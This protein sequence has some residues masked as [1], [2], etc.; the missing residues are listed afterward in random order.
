MEIQT[1]NQNKTRQ[2]RAMNRKVLSGTVIGVFCIGISPL[3]LSCG[4]VEKTQSKA[5]S[6]FTSKAWKQQ[7]EW[8]QDQ[9]DTDFLFYIRR[10]DQAEEL[11]KNAIEKAKAFGNSDPR[12]ARSLTSLGRIQ[13]NQSNYE[14]AHKSLSHAF[15][16]K[17]K[18]FGMKNTDV[19]D[20]LCELAYT[21]L[22]QEDLEGANNAAA[23]A[24]NI[25][26]E[27]NDQYGIIESD[28][29]AALILSKQ[30][31]EKEALATYGNCIKAY[32]NKIDNPLETLSSENLH[33]MKNCFH[34]YIELKKTSDPS[35]NLKDEEAELNKLTAWLNVLG[36]SGI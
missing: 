26:Q 16:I 33:R 2:K 28:Y 25:R 30:E 20:I 5:D 7:F 36:E 23:Q 12:L 27:L 21:D 1:Q 11:A 15:Q 6:H 8:F 17:S 32:M 14:A 34:K 31:K 4:Q 18:K 3:L 22:N 13:L 35:V 9:Q 24:R 10:F 29:L 19:A